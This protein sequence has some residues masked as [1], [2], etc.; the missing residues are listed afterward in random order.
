MGSLVTFYGV[1]E[2]GMG[3]GRKLGFPTFN[4]RVDPLPELAHGVYAVRAVIDGVAGGSDASYK[5]LMHFGPKPTVLMDEIFC[6]VYLMDVSDSGLATN[7]SGMDIE[8]L[9]KIRDVMRFENLDA[10]V[11]QMKNDEIVAIERYFS[12]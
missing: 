12:L 3:L 5:G 4:L 8:V 6:E 11:E 10:L 7:I 1:V 2:R 9:G